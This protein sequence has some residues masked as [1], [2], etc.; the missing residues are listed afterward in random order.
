MRYLLVNNHCITDPTA[1]V[2]QSLRTIVQ[3]LAEAGHQCHV[4]TTARFESPVTFTIDAHL[5]S[6]GVEVEE[7]R[8]GSSATTGANARRPVLRFRVGEADVTLLKTRRNDETRPDRAETAQFLSTFAQL[9]AD[10]KPDQ[11]IACNAHPMI[12][13]VL[14]EARKNGMTTAYAIR[15]FGYYDRRYFEHVN[16][17]FTCSQFL[18][19]VYRDRIG[20]VSTPLEPPIAWSTVVAPT[21]S[22]AFVTFVHPAPHKGLYL[23]ARLASMLGAQRPDIPILVVQSGHSAGAL[24]AIPGIDFSQYPQIMAAPAVPSPADYFALTRILLVPSVWD[25]PFGRVAAEALINGVPPIVS[26]RGSLPHVVGG[27][28][29]EGGAGRVVPLPEWMTFRTTRLPDA[30]E[31]EPWFRAVCELWDDPARYDALADRGR[32]LAQARYGE[33]ASRRLHVDYFTHLGPEGRPF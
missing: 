26:D 11:V 28:E 17:A 3:W 22:R 15:G 6:M 1:G 25:E 7:S 33:A 19:D 13:A 5:R 23:F 24:N 2:T 27:D 30:S 29:A 9:A 21:E 12:Q 18:T 20:L 16:H 10:L 14:A 31:V 32:R 8:A 4:L